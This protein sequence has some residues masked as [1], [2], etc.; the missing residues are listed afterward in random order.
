MGINLHQIYG[1][2]FIDDQIPLFVNFRNLWA[3]HG[4]YISI[5]YS[6]TG[7]LHST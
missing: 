5:H 3:D 7:S 6:G 2:K 4:D 1:Q